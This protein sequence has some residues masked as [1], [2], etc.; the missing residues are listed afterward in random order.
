MTTNE[1]INLVSTAKTAALLFGSDPKKIYHDLAMALHPDTVDKKYKSTA[2]HVFT[3]V[4]Q[5]YA[6]LNGKHSTIEKVIGQWVV[7]EPL[8]KGDLCDVYNARSLRDDSVKAIFKLARSPKDTDL[9]EQEFVSL[10]ILHKADGDNF[11]KYLPK[12]L[13]RVEASY[14]RANVIAISENSHSLEDIMG[15]YPYGIDFRHAIWMIN[16]ALSVLAFS[17][18]NG[19]VHGA[20]TPDHLLYGPVSHS[21]TLIDWCYSVSAESKKY[22]PAIIVKNKHIYPDEVLRKMPAHP[23]TDIY[24]L[25]ASIKRA[26]K[27]PKEFK[28]IFEWCMAESPRSRPKD[29][30]DLQD[31]WLQ[32]AKDV[33]GEPKYTKLEIPV[34]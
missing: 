6:E 15:L 25:F 17:H 11:K 23:A 20:I 28:A 32:T 4:S 19:I 8:A 1:A 29:C 12:V 14:R 21:L 10:G 2:I 16:R 3:K 27:P 9:L 7:G 13:D 26:A 22:I 5:M 18:A 24:M 33:Y 30:F 34:T 31:R